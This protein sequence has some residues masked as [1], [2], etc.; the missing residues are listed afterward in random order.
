MKLIG[1]VGDHSNWCLLG[2]RESPCLCGPA[3][4]HPSLCAGSQVLKDCFHY[5]SLHGGNLGPQFE[6]CLAHQSACVTSLRSYVLCSEMRYCGGNQP[7]FHTFGGLGVTLALHHL[8]SCPTPSQQ[9]NSV[10]LAQWRRG[11]ISPVK[12]KTHCIP[13]SLEML[14]WSFGGGR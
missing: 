13:V 1:T 8:Y 5:L 4:I 12:V 11:L 14:R 9:S 7:R 2:L 6:G 10:G 3:C